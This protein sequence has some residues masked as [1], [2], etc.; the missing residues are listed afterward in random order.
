MAPGYI[1][2]M[3]KLF[4]LTITQPVEVVCTAKTNENIQ[5]ISKQNGM[6]I[7]YCFTEFWFLLSYTKVICD[8]SKSVDP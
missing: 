8:K 2:G 4:L 3:S 6:Q 5:S 1:E 7:Q